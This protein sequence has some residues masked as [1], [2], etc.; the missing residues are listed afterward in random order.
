M[1]ELSASELS[2]ISGN[3][4]DYPVGPHYKAPETP[5][6]EKKGGGGHNKS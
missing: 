5:A 1:R 6:P 2:A 3:A 4:S